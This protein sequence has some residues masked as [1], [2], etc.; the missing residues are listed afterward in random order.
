MTIKTRF[1]PSPTGFLHIGSLRTALYN[2]YFARKHNGKFLL[3]IEDTDQARYVE[4]AVESLLRTLKRMDIDFDEGPFVQSERLGIY[5]EHA[6]QL[7]QSGHAYHCFCSKQRLDELRTTQQLAKKPTKYD[8]ACLSLSKDEVHQ[9]LTDGQPFVLRMQIPEG[10]TTFVDEI[11]GTIKINNDEMDDQVLIKADG[12]P[13]Y[14]LAVVVDDHLM[15]VTHIIRGEEW[16]SS[17]PKHILLYEWFGFPLPVFAHLPL[18]LNPDRS[19]LSKRQGDVSVED[20]LSKGYLE[21]ALINYVSLLGFN[22]SAD[23]EI[24]TR[25]ELIASFDLKKVNKSGA[26][27]DVN[28]LL[29]MNGKYLSIMSAHEL[30]LRVRPFLDR[31]GDI[32]TSLLER[33]CEVE[34]T[35][36]NIL[37]DSRESVESYLSRPDYHADL[38]VW[39]KSDRKDALTQLKDVRNLLAGLDNKVFSDAGLIEQALKRYIMDNGLQNGNVLWPVRAA[40]SGKQKSAGPHELVWIFAKEETLRRIDHA[41]DLLA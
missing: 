33:I 38:L 12:F 4:G 32:E 28:K 27:F 39:K 35:R 23:Q 9:R 13:T 20:Y 24:Y 10:I 5:K 37:S 25:D 2:Y 26:I 36:W 30:A 1:P 40:L 22:P 7:V 6:N 19:K 18:I 17:V 41:I 11:R 15:G 31:V 21:E 14:H 8:R 3:R 34:K 16:L 29:W